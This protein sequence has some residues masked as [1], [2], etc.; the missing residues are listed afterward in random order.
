MLPNRQFVATRTAGVWIL[1]NQERFSLDELNGLLD[2]RPITINPLASN[3]IR[4]YE[5]APG[6]PDQKNISTSYVLV[7]RNPGEMVTFDLLLRIAQ[8]HEAT[9]LPLESGLIAAMSLVGCFPT[10]ISSVLLGHTPASVRRR[11]EKHP[12]RTRLVLWGASKNP[13][14]LSTWDVKGGDRITPQINAVLF[15]LP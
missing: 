12:I 3:V 15:S 13:S 1:R 7:K 10:G 8:R 5:G 14:T 11:D 2:I 6:K 4:T 9:I